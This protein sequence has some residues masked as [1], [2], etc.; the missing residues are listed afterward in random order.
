MGF[1]L[2]AAA[3]ILFWRPAKCAEGA[4]PEA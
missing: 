3:M 2:I 4:V 1:E